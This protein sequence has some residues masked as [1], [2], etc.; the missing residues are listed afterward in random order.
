MDSYLLRKR[1][2][3]YIMDNWSENNHDLKKISCVYTILSLDYKS[4]DVDIAY[5]GSTVDI[6]SR[7]K[8]HKVPS[9]VQNMGLINLLYFLPMDIGFYDYERKLIK[10]LQP[11]FNKQHK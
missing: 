2:A 10:K 11:I 8:S 5:V 4:Q 6:F 7:Y 1:F 9:K 3:K